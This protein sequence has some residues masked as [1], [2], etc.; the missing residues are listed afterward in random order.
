M[1]AALLLPDIDQKAGG[2]KPSTVQAEPLIDKQK[3]VKLALEAAIG[4]V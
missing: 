4:D 2:N 1:S 3:G